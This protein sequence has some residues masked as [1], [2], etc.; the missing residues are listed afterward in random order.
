MD[1]K[2]MSWPAII[3]VVTAS[4]AVILGALIGMLYA[5][6]IA[7]DR[8]GIGWGWV[9]LGLGIVAEELLRRES[10]RRIRVLFSLAIALIGAGFIAFIV[11]MFD[12]FG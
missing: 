5:I 4:M 8:F 12:W 2:D 1:K 10:T 7:T 9:P 3:L 11:A 6:H